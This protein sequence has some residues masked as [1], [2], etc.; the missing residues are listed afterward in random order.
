MIDWMFICVLIIALV[1]LLIVIL[2]EDEINPIW[3]F[4]M[5]IFDIALWWSL[6]AGNLEIEYPYQIYN[7]TS[8]NI[9]TSYQ[10]FSSKTSPALTYIFGAPA[11]ILIVY[12]SYML[13]RTFKPV[14][15]KMFGW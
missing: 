10:V 9:E 11:I 6:A 8:G 12:M 3:I 7:A 4:G 2:F 5:L 1:F 13:Y 14:F 15:K